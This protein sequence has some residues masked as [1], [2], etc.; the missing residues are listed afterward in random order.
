[1]IFFLSSPDAEAAI[2]LH[3]VAGYDLIRVCNEAIELLLIPDEACLFMALE[4]P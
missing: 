3:V 4:N 2:R 1:M